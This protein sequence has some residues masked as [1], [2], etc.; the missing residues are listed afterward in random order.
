MRAAVLVADSGTNRID[1]A[2]LRNPP[3]AGIL[4]GTKG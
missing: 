2:L 1:L 3:A 4:E